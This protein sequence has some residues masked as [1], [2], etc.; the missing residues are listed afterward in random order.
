M[1]RCG[2]PPAIGRAFAIYTP[3]DLELAEHHVARGEQHVV[4]Q[5][6]LITELR[7]R[8]QPIDLAEYLLHHFNGLLDQH[9]LH[10]DQI[11][12]DLGR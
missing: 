7:L 9:R 5:E 11:K 12:A 3:A 1:V 6:K 10:R 8:G 4:D 2:S